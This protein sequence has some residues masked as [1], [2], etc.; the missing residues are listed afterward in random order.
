[1]IKNNSSIEL[2]DQEK[3]KRRRRGGTA[4]AWTA[5]AEAATQQRNWKV[6][7]KYFRNT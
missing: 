6:P 3:T 7:H 1:M 5:K 4:P 2:I